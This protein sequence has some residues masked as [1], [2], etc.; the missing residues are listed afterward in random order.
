MFVSSLGDLGKSRF[1]KMVRKLGKPIKAVSRLTPAIAINRTL[2]RSVPG[3]KQMNRVSGNRIPGSGGRVQGNRLMRRARNIQAR[4]T[5]RQQIL[6]DPALAA[7]TAQF[8]A[9]TDTISAARIQP[10]QAEFQPQPSR[11]ELE[12]PQASIEPQETVSF[13]EQDSGIPEYDEYQQFAPAQE[14]EMVYQ[15]QAD[16]FAPSDEV[17]TED[18]VE[19]EEPADGYEDQMAIDE[20]PEDTMLDG[21]G[22]DN[23]I[24]RNRNKQIKRLMKNGR[25][26]RQVESHVKFLGPP[27]KEQ[28]GSLG[29]APWLLAA[30]QQ[31][32]SRIQERAAKKQAKKEAQ[33]QIAAQ[34][35]MYQAESPGFFSGSTPWMIVGGVAVLGLGAWLF[36]GKKRATA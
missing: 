34:A 1:K 26:R 16:Q 11:L 23:R 8:A 29:V 18:E 9:M 33:Q 4:N 5:K 7:R 22:Y 13:P 2:V 19:F 20:S 6:R 27:I 12:Q 30:G 15:E 21:L 28:L 31:A 36:L 3:K 32:I 10:S 17:P 24:K 35:S 14:E 25:H